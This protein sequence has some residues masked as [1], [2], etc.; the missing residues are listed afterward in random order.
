MRPDCSA[1]VL[2]AA[3]TPFGRRGGALS[4]WH[5][6]DLS[7]QVL[8]GLLAGVGAAGELVDDVI[9]GC[10]TQVGAQAGN[11]ARRAALAAGWPEQVPGATVDRH[12]V[13]SA[14]AVHWA[15]QAVA[16]GAQ[17]L[18]VAGGVE[19]TSRVPLGAALAQ[20]ATGKPF[21]RLLSARY[22]AGAG[23][24]PPGLVAEEV[25]RRWALGRAALDA[26][27]AG[28]YRKAEAAQRRLASFILPV[29]AVPPSPPPVPGAA[30]G[31][32]DVPVLAKPARA[33]GSAVISRDEN[34][35]RRPRRAELAA[36]SPAYVDGGVV[37]AANMAAEGDGA[38]AVLV[39][40]P[41][42]A[43]ALRLEPR[44]RL[45]AF[46]T[47]GASPDIWPLAAV[48][49]AL[50]ALS[51]A[52]LRVGDVARWHVLESSAAAVLAWSA[53]MGVALERVNREGGALASTAPTGAVGAA[54]F[55]AAVAGLV[56]DPSGPVVVCG[57]GE[58]GVGTACVL[59][60]AS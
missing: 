49:A 31:A 11:I 4:A 7:A 57:A 18:V 29:P 3:R 8:A 24:P 23:L 19:V 25:A 13:S 28:S 59:A 26:F 34:V 21:G 54:L 27:T 36:L 51:C 14:Q 40:R 53:E 41:A 60:P 38:G 6:V 47:A 12:A 16:S 22:G 48:P 33:E 30:A 1:V 37:T 46:A 2:G 56:E 17:D 9:W 58:G 10:T 55:V 39:A 52:R 45:V 32:T 43:R 15:A 42:T 35:G 50:R 44:A 5:P 20:P